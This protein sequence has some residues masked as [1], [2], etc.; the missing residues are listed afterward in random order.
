[1]PAGALR[2]IDEVVV[3]GVGPA[4]LGG[5]PMYLPGCLLLE[6]VP[7]LEVLQEPPRWRRQGLS[8]P[9]PLIARRLDDTYRER[10]GMGAQAQGRGAAGR[11]P[12]HD[13]NVT[14]AGHALRASPRFGQ[15][16]PIP[17]GYARGA[18]ASPA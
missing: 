14:R 3:V 1:M 8:E 2:D 16:P 4:P 15:Q 9:L 5:G 7:D 12:T 11:A 18:H 6:F 13:G 10:R 17:R